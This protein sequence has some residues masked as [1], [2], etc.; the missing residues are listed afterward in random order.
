M[1]LHLAV[2]ELHLHLA[3]LVQRGFAADVI[4]LVL[5]EEELDA[6][7]VFVRHI[8]RTLDDLAPVKAQFVEG[9]AKLRRA[10][11]HQVVELGV[12]QERLG[13]DA[14]PVQ[15][16]AAGAFFFDAGDSFAELCGANRA[17]VAGGSAADY[18]EV[19]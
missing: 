2:G 14:A 17:D 10:V 18:D 1:R 13:R 6:R 9:E 4:D 16:G 19:V 11:R 12:A 3:S 15:A 7:G 8:A 5:L